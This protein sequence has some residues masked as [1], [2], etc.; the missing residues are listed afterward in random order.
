MGHVQDSPVATT[1]ISNEFMIY[2]MKV[3][4]VSYNL[5][6]KMSKS[7]IHILPDYGQTDSKTAI[8]RGDTKTSVR[9]L[10]VNFL[11]ISKNN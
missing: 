6:Q 1:M 2:H 11:K 3:H 10:Q 9:W 5:S 8:V 7:R 4:I